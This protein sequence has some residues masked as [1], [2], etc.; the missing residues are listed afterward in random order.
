MKTLDRE[1]ARPPLGLLAGL[2]LLALGLNAWQTRARERDRPMPLDELVAAAAAPLQRGFGAAGRWLDHKWAGLSRAGRLTQENRQLAQEAAQLRA[3]N[4]QL[5]EEILRQGRLRPLLA[6]RGEQTG[7]AVPASV[8]GQTRRESLNYLV[9]DRGRRDGLRPRL[10]VVASTGAVG[11]VY[12]VTAATARVLP[13]TASGSGAA[14]IV[15]RTRAAG[16]VRGTGGRVCEMRYLQAEVDVRQG[17]LVLTS[18]QGGIYPRGLLIGRVVGLARD[19]RTSSRIA[20]V[21]PAV[22]FSS[23]E[24]AVVYIPPS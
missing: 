18:G 8:I 19:P 20:L 2:L 4:L 9:L 12:A 5:T 13:L 17:D 21:S 7:R 22:D 10:P 23:L 24:E 6:S 15:Q 3:E 1:L 14:A 16:V 11:Q